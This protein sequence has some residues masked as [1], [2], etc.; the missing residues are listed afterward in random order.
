MQKI[1]TFSKK[2]NN[3][4]FVIF[5]F[6]ILTKRLLKTSLI[7]NNQ[8]LKYIFIPSYCKIKFMTVTAFF[9]EFELYYTPN[10]YIVP[11]E[12]RVHF[13]PHILAFSRRTKMHLNG[14]LL[15]GTEFF[16]IIVPL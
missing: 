11:M 13:F 10:G 5:K 4:A 14:M 8:L 3:S 2:K 6:E 9:H 7:L 12:F 16:K 15:I 1:L